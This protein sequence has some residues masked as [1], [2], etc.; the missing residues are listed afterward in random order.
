MRKNHLLNK[1]T[2]TRILLIN[3]ERAT[4]DTHYWNC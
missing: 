2:I 3:I 4:K 1:K